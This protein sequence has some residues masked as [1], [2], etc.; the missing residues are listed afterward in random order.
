MIIYYSIEEAD[1][2]IE[3]PDDEFDSII[4]GLERFVKKLLEEVIKFKGKRVCRIAF[5]GYLG[6]DWDKII[7]RTLER[8]SEYK[9]RLKTFN[10]LESYNVKLLDEV[11]ER[12]LSVD[13]T[14]GYVY[15]GRITELL[16]RDR[17]L[18]LRAELLKGSGEFDGVV[19]F[20]PGSANSMLRREYDIIF[21]FDVTREALFN[22]SERKPVYYIGAW[23]KGCSA[24]SY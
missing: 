20:G 16:D 22:G 17:V 2:Y 19:C 1:N 15:K 18:E 11:V 3:L 12:S 7:S 4:V 6:V 5:D 14:F 9:I 23:G 24:P 13:K 8:S 21:Y 10:F